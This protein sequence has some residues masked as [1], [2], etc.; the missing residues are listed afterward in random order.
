MSDQKM[1]TM[2]IMRSRKLIFCK[3]FFFFFVLVI[4]IFFSV[5]VSN[6]CKSTGQYLESAVDECFSTHNP[7][8][9]D[10]GA[11]QR[12][13]MSSACREYKEVFKEVRGKAIKALGFAKL[14]QKDLGI[15]A[16][17][18]ITTPV[19]N[20]FQVLKESQHTLVRILKCIS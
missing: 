12:H 18:F 3:N 17:Y 16:N 19:D 13:K 8:E 5:L 14:L 1:M 7:K 4:F 6:L 15:A 11:S 9:E 20:V 2:L 10:G